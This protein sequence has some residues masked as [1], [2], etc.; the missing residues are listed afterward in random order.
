MISHVD[1]T[2]LVAVNGGRFKIA[3][4]DQGQINPI[5][6]I[7]PPASSAVLHTDVYPRA[8]ELITELFDTGFLLLIVSEPVRFLFAGA[9]PGCDIIADMPPTK[10]AERDDS[11]GICSWRSP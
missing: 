8:Q 10:N 4:F 2:L 7:Q 6:K 11:L 1:A 9:I 5:P 3:R